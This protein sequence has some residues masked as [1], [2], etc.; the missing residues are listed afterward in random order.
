MKALTIVYILLACT[1]AGYTQT[2]ATYDNVRARQQLTLN[3]HTL[4]SVLQTIDSLSTHAQ[5]VTAKAVYDYIATKYSTVSAGTGI[6]VV[7]AGSNYTISLDTL[8]RLHFRTD[9][10]YTGGVGTMRWN[11]TDGT[12]DLGLLGGNVTLQLG[13]ESVQR[14]KHADNSGLV[15]GRV[16]YLVGSD[17]TNPTVRYARANTDLTSAN[18]FGVMTE[19]ASGGSKAFC[20]TFGLVRNI[21]TNN[22]TEGGLVWLSKDTAGALTAVRPT[23][24]N[25]GVEIGFCIR[26]H[27]TQGVVFVTVQNGYELN[28]LHDVY[29]PS[30]SNNQ[31]LLW[32]SANSRWEA[33]AVD[34]SLNNEGRLIG[35]KP[36]N[37][38]Y[39]NIGS[40]TNGSLPIILYRGSGIGFSGTSGSP[41]GG[42]LTISNTGDLDSS[43]E[44]ILGVDAGAANTSVITSNTTSATG[45]TVSGGTGIAV[46]ETTS[47]NGGTITVTNS[48]PDQTVSLSNGGGIGVTGT[49]PSFTLTA[50][51]QSASN[52]GTLGVGAGTSTSSVITSN[53]SGASGVTLNAGGGISISETTSSNGGSITL[54]ATDQSIT[55]E[56]ILGVATN[57]G[58]DAWLRSNTSTANDIGIVGTNNTTINATASSNGGQIVIDSKAKIDTFSLSGQ[59]LRASLL[60]DGVAA[61]SV[62][63]PIVDVVAGTNV[64]VTKSNGVAT[65]SATGGGG[66]GTP[67]GNTGEIQYN[68]AGAFGASA[69]LA[70]DNVNK[71]FGLIGDLSLSNLDATYDGATISSELA[72][73]GSGTNWSGLS[74]STG[75]THTPGSTVALTANSLTIISGNIYA[76]DYTI[77][78]RTAGTVT[79]TIGGRSSGAVST[80]GSIERLPV[81]SGV[82]LVV[83]PQSTFDGTISISVK[84][85]SASNAIYKG[86]SSNGNLRYE[87]RIPSITQNLFIGLNTGRYN[88]SAINNTFIGSEAGQLNVSGY[89]NTFI[90]RRAGA[91]NSSGFRNVFIGNETGS[92]NINGYS[93]VYIGHNAGGSVADGSGSVAIGSFTGGGGVFVGSNAGQGNTGGNNSVFG[94]Y[95]GTNNISGNH[96]TILGSFCSTTLSS[97]S[98]NTIA[99][100]YAGGTI[101]GSNNS[102]FGHHSGRNNTTGSGNCFFGLYSGAYFIGGS[103]VTRA[104]NSI[105]IGVNAGFNGNNETNQIVIG[106]SVFGLGS[107][108]TSI[109]NSNTVQTHLYG[110]TTIGSNTTA[111]ARLHVQGGNNTSNTY[112]LIVTNS[113]GS[114]TTPAICAQNDQKIGIGTNSVDSGATLEVDGTTGGILFPR[115][116]TTNRDALTPVNGLVIYNST[117]NKLQVYAGGAWVDLH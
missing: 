47:T 97:G 10:T 58:A 5:G 73:T 89:D 30:P 71:K 60:N 39:Y 29:A 49:Y 69:N 65:V 50:T 21:N 51:D 13:Q 64:T 3:G 37:N 92:A 9:S 52:E 43:N 76:V 95:S 53:T 84:L 75:Y 26:K 8:K 78:N 22:L 31:G 6:D 38:S 110:N 14:V 81:L 25:H 23:A 35:F 19:D 20:T 90:G 11:L 94:S 82:T 74:F 18:T 61:S 48:A 67:A 113:G 45:V 83:T 17:G 91:S 62:T 102:F 4:T 115:L 72:T 32:K 101:T 98:G 105:A 106:N 77:T 34:T 2:T 33:A 54:S 55:N 85:I 59:T 79:I 86:Y 117:T 46:T 114:T 57:P 63:L 109:G 93:I 112:S 7:K 24:P 66:G 12:L 108:T 103:N 41:E 15:Q 68:N 116:S 28:E 107:N 40:S 70:W 100:V 104:D 96:N 99:G 87:Q 16:V 27:A 42:D 1:V 56:G 111:S 80:S 36:S 44:G 88:L